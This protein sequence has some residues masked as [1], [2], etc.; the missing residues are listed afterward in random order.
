MGVPTLTIAGA[1]PPGR[2][3]TANMLRA[4]LAGF[5]ARDA[6][7]FVEL[8]VKWS[9]D[10]PGLAQVRASGRERLE[11]APMRQP[12]VI[13]AGLH[14]ALR[15]MWQRWCSGLPPE[16]IDV[17]NVVEERATFVAPASPLQ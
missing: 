6:G 1:T 13:A 3:G 15:A 7:E 4:G 9:N 16:P 2:Q 10:L 11:R 12:G 14:R 8:G 17:S 5:V